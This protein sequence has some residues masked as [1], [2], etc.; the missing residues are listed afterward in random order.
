MKVIATM[1]GPANE[2]RI[3]DSADVAPRHT[4]HGPPAEPLADLDC[5][6]YLLT[7]DGEGG[8]EVRSL[9][10]VGMFGTIFEAEV[11]L[12]L[13]PKPAGRAGQQDLAASTGEY[14]VGEETA[15]PQECER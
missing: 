11:V 15:A 3:L 9:D 2:F 7:G 14:P 12:T 6:R 10:G 8:R 5:G 4:V 1:F 13:P